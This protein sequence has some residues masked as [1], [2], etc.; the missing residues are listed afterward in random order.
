MCKILNKKWGLNKEIIKLWLKQIVK[1]IVLYG[2]E[3]WGKIS[4]DSGI[5]KIIVNSI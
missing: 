3:V 2:A 4:R 1:L 5:R